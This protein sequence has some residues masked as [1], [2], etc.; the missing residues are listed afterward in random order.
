MKVE[1]KKFVIMQEQMKFPDYKN[2][3]AYLSKGYIFAAGC[4]EVGVAPLAGP[5]VAAA[6]ILDPTSIGKYRSKNKWYARVRDSKTTNE[7][8]RKELLQEILKHVKAFG[9]GEV[10]HTEIDEINIHHASRLAMRRAVEELSKKISSEEKI[11]IFIDGR[12]KIP[13]IT[14]EQK[15]I[16]KGDTSV[17][18]I[19]AASIIAKVHRDNIMHELHDKF[20]EYG[21]ARHKGYGTREHQQALKK[22]GASSVH[23]K[24]FIK[25]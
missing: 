5:V 10:T 18:S 14:W 15:T 20:P 22:F 13:D 16:V 19:S 4:D 3:L 2:E 11:I 9:V 6:C 23:R 1:P 24:T 7:E 25:I 17:L 12:F 21:F 8:E